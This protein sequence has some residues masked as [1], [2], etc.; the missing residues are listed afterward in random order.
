MTLDAAALDDA[1]IQRAAAA[2]FGKTFELHAELASTNDRA[3]EL[4]ASGAPEGTLVVALRQTGGRGRPGRAWASP[5]GGLYLSLVLRPDKGM[6]ERASL[7][8]VAGLAAGEALDVAGR[9]ATSLKWPNDVLLDGK[10]IGGL[11]AEVTRERNEAVVILGVG[12]NVDTPADA[13][14]PEVRAIATSLRAA[15]GA[16]A[17]LEAVLKHFL[18]HLEGH[19]ESVR[20]GSGALLLSKAADRMTMLGSKVRVKLADRVVEGVASGLNATGALVVAVEGK[21]N[22]II[23]AGDVEELRPVS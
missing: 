5:P 15:K 22:E 12:L 10:K 6:L 8:L 20:K 7:A 13:F 14:P 3:K 23:Y 21:P 4:A 1:A 2:R 19:Y 18:A 11:L 16:P 9:T 17:S